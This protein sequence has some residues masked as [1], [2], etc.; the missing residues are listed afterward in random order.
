[1]RGKKEKPEPKKIYDSGQINSLLVKVY[2]TSTRL[3]EATT[4][5]DKLEAEL[6]LKMEIHK[7]RTYLK[8]TGVK[9]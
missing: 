8:E 9:K 2:L 4:S 7:V 5:E 6:D 3:V 1:M